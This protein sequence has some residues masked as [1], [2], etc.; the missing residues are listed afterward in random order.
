MVRAATVSGLCNTIAVII[1]TLG[2]NIPGECYYNLSLWHTII[3]NWDECT[4]S[5]TESRPMHTDSHSWDSCGL[6]TQ[7][8]L[9]A[10][11]PSNSG[12]LHSPI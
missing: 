12:M 3:M 4:L 5:S 2:L 6:G 1:I 10:S 9:R 8:M 11:T 7:I